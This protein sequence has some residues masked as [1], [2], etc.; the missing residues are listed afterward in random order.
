MLLQ[1]VQL[2]CQISIVLLHS[3]TRRY[4]P[5]CTYSTTPKLSSVV[6]RSS[7]AKISN[8]K[9]NRRK[10]PSSQFSW[11]HLKNKQ[12]ISNQSRDQPDKTQT[13]K[14]R[15]MNQLPIQS[16]CL[17]QCTSMLINNTWTISSSVVVGRIYRKLRNNMSVPPSSLLQLGQ[18]LLAGVLILHAA[19]LFQLFP[20]FPFAFRLSPTFLPFFLFFFCFSRGERI[21]YSGL[22]SSGI[23]ES[24][25]QSNNETTKQQTIAERITK[26]KIW[27]ILLQTDNLISPRP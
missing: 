21:S 11:Y 1:S 25:K 5:A 4:L 19:W 18:Q 24:K 17:H 7:G 26:A 6:C 20:R 23:K 27:G 16:I 2:Q 8:Q 13:V 15:R 10:S 9:V 14:H 12:W 22:A 3:Y